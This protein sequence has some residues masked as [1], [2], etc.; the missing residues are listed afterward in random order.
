M[1]RVV[2]KCKE[3][4]W[5]HSTIFYH[6]LSN[7]ILLRHILIELFFVIFIYFRKLVASRK[8]CNVTAIKHLYYY[9]VNP[10]NVWVFTN[11]INCI[12]LLLFS[13]SYTIKLYTEMKTR[14]SNST[15]N[16]FHFLLF[17]VYSFVLPY[18][19]VFY[20]SC[21]GSKGGI[22]FNLFFLLYS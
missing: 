22:S 11:G 8:F 1:V 14:H 12:I 21:N 5:R 2:I 7:V 17:L 18:T 3:I 9:T 19:T 10:T 4:L 13:C 6:H 16:Y 20:Q 15:I